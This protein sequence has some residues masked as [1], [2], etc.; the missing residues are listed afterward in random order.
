M[1]FEIK[2]LK[3]NTI[4]AT[5]EAVGAV[6]PADDVIYIFGIPCLLSSAEPIC[7]KE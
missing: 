4:I 2:T 5:L 3:G 7:T 1:E 6:Y